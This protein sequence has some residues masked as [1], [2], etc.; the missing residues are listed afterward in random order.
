[1]ERQLS[2]IILGSGNV[3]SHLGPAL[4]DAGYNILQV[5][6]RNTYSGSALAKEI[7]SAY[8]NDIEQLSTEAD[9]ILFLLPNEGIDEMIAKWPSGFSRNILLLH[10][11]GSYSTSKLAEISDEY[12]VFYPLQSFKQGVSLDLEKT[13][14]LLDTNTD[15]SYK[16]VQGIAKSISP[17]HYP[18]TD[19]GREKIHLAAV[20][21]NNFTNAI[22]AAAFEYLDKE[23]INKKPLEPI[24]EKTFQN[25]LKSHPAKT[26][27]G[28]AIRSENALLA[29]QLEL[30]K[31][32]PEHASIYKSISNYI[33]K[34]IG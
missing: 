25:L 11:S 24:I 32:Y 14:L 7:H 29:K 4:Y 31:E 22:F 21:I 17:L 10:S 12:G 16:T 3:A 18:F 1:M 2:L 26:Q 28:P 8:I 33:Q 30:L 13:P 27:T 20:F 5:F 34:H 6:S 9:V 19:E 15:S 23:N